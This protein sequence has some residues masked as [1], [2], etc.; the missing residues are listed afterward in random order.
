MGLLWNPWLLRHHEIPSWRFRND[1][2]F[3]FISP[4]AVDI[5][6]NRTSCRQWQ[7]IYWIRRKMSRRQSGSRTSRRDENV[8]WSQSVIKDR[9]GSN[10]QIL[11]LL[12]KFTFMWFDFLS[13]RKR[14]RERE[15]RLQPWPFEKGF[16]SN[17]RILKIFRSVCFPP[18]RTGQL[19]M[20][21]AEYPIS[22]L[23]WR[24]SSCL[25]FV[26]LRKSCWKIRFF[27]SLII[28]PVFI[29]SFLLTSG[30]SS[31][32]LLCNASRVS[33]VLLFHELSSDSSRLLLDSSMIFSCLQPH[34]FFFFIWDQENKKR[35]ILMEL[36][37]GSGR[38]SLCPSPPPSHSEQFFSG[39][40]RYPSWFWFLSY[41]HLT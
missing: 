22:I 21:W 33:L 16:I 20:M 25:P 29:G 32:L 39:W 31:I 27:H 1:V 11:F 6:K 37:V 8:T 23:T 19:I 4:R 34:L 40:F 2:R 28:H 36:R 3:T 24:S 5:H 41:L 12:S 17:G 26:L 7:H 14:E 9:N 15:N 13:K 38:R 30:S 10:L 18:I 35:E